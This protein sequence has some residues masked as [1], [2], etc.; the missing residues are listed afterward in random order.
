MDLDNG[1]TVQV[2]DL[3]RRY[4]GDFYLVKL[5]IRCL[6]PLCREHFESVEAFT[7]AVTN[8]GETAL[9]R[10]TIEKMGVPAGEVGESIDGLMINFEKNSLAYLSSSS[11]PQKLVM[12]LLNKTKR[13]VPRRG[14]PVHA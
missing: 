2:Y 11:F 10:R 1:L 13:I 7:E 3:T 5:E 8:L 9:F 6:V 14:I 4:Y 12:S